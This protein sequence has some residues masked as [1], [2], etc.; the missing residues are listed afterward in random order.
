MKRSAALALVASMIAVPLE[1]QTDRRIEDVETKLGTAVEIVGQPSPKARL[2][3]KMREMHVPGVSIAVIQGGRI[4]WAK[5]YGKTAGNGGPV[6][7]HTCFQA[8]S[9]SK[10]VTAL[11]A[12]RL[13]AEGKV[14]L[15]RPV[16][17]YL[18]SWK[19]PDSEAGKAESVTLRGLLS[20]TAGLNVH[21]FPG[22]AKGMAVPSVLEILDGRAPANTP[23][24]RIVH[25]PGAAWNYSGGGYVVAQQLI[26]D[27]TGRPFA[28]VGKDTILAPAGMHESSFDQQPTCDHAL[29]HNGEGVTVPGGYHVYP[30]MAAAGLWTTASD[31]ARAM[32]SLA[33]RPDTVLT[34]IKL[35][36]SVGFDTG[37]T[38]EARWISKGGDTEGFAAFLVF[39]PLKGEGAVVMTNGAQGATLARDVIR[40][41]ASA[42]GWPDFGPRIRNATAVSPTLLGR[43]PGTYHYRET[44]SFTIT[45]SGDHL[46]ISS[47]GETPETLHA[48]PSGEFFTLSQD[49]AF[50]FE[51]DAVTGHI[52]IGDT[53]IPFSKEN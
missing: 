52:A 48:D 27:V 14:S 34:P 12:L 26:Q 23:P 41:V 1:A 17:D 46:V 42:Y 24:I 20:H 29:G 33:K 28:A 43:L 7:A 18:K 11:G 13:V 45:R 22:Y 30:E 8:G 31:L 16:N 47:P 4:A 40:G 38:G 15:D 6:T 37:G 3:D 5:G 10:S 44:N 9:I 19:L 49:V 53:K 50:L 51:P 35:G 21:G 39:Y 2:T 32:L 36:H 25:Q